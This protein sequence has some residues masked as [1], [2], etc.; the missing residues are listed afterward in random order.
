MKTTTYLG[1][2]LLQDVASSI[3]DDEAEFARI[4]INR[5]GSLEFEPHPVYT[6][7]GP[8]QG[9]QTFGQLW[10]YVR[11]YR[12]YKRSKWDKRPILQR[13]YMRRN[14]NRFWAAR[15][16]WSCGR[17]AFAPVGYHPDYFNNKV[18]DA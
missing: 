9:K 12:R 11:T 17:L 18:D 14:W 6:N 16:F 15:W 10:Y 3:V 4:K 1:A 8:G 7:N 13:Y 5:D 2:R